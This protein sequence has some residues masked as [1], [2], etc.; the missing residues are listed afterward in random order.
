MIYGIRSQDESVI[1]KMNELAN[2][3]RS[4]IKVHEYMA[5]VL[6][7]ITKTGSCAVE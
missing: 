1:M 5:T 6:H 4:F 3:V 7:I 2:I